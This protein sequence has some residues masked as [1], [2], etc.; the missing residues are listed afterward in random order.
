MVGMHFGLRAG[1]CDRRGKDE[2]EPTEPTEPTLGATGMQLRHH[3]FRKPP[4]D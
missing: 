1:A 4:Y 2:D 3:T